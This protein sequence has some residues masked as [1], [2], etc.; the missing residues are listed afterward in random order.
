V[1][2]VF[3]DPA[4]LDAAVAA[5]VVRSSGLRTALWGSA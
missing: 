2:R 4:V 1:A 3:G 5:R